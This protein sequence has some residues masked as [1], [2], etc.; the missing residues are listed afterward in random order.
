[1][2]CR[3]SSRLLSEALDR[4]LTPGERREVEEHLAIC[5]ACTRCRRQFSALRHG[6]RRVLRGEE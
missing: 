2:N 1:M 5:P 6:V 3:R 4:E